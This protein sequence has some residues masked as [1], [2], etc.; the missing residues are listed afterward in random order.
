MPTRLER[1][2]RS[3]DCAMTALT[4]SRLVPLAAQ[5][6]EEPLPYSTPAKMTSGVPSSLYFMAAS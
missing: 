4:P 6:R 2:I 3:N 5:S 1:W